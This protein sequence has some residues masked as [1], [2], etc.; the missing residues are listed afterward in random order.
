MTPQTFIF[1]GRSGCGKGTQAKLLIKFLEKNDKEHKVLHIESGEEIREFIKGSSYT[2][3]V[4]RDIYN[5]GGLIPEFV[6]VYLWT[7]ALIANFT[8]K[9]HLVFD[10]MPRK[11]HEAGALGSIFDFYGLSKPWVINVD[12]SHKEA[13]KRLLAR[14]RSD[15]T[16]EEIEK[17]LNWYETDVMPTMAYYDSNPRCNFLKV[18]G[19]R[20]V[21]E[22]HADIVK[23]VGL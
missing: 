12:I 18:N 11:V 15:D 19:E 2:Q 7:A 9:E 1:I 10:G 4:A 17:R 21:E 23:K 5:K 6:V 13:V 8:G 22:I 3:G 14:K 20:S 16:K